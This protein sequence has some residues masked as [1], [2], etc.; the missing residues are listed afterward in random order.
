M[1]TF[2]REQCVEGTPS[3]DAN[4]LASLFR[5]L[6]ATLKPERGFAPDKKVCPNIATCNHA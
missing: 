1:L 5:L 2:I 3:V 6:D 4:L